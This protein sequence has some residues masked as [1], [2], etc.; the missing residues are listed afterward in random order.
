MHGFPPDTMQV[1]EGA[2]REVRFKVGAA[3]IYFYRGVASDSSDAGPTRDAEPSGAFIVD[4]LG[5]PAIA[6]S[7]FSYFALECEAVTGRAA[8][9]QAHAAS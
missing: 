9:G 7:C 3:G 1:R 8:R 5:A 2:T 4:P 6:R